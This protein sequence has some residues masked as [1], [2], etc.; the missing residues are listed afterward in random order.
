MI[1]ILLATLVSWSAISS[2]HIDGPITTEHSASDITDFYAFPDADGLVMV[3]NLYPG[4]PTDA[5]FEDR[6]I[7]S[8]LVRS[9]NIQDQST[10]SHPE[11]E[12]KIHCRFN[13]AHLSRGQISC[14]SENGAIS[15]AGP[16]DTITEETGVQIYSGLR[17]DPFIFNGSFAKSIVEKGTLSKPGSGNDMNQLNVL[18]VVIKIPA[19][20]LP[21][22]ALIA[23]ATEVSFQEKGSTNAPEQLD[24]VGRPEITNVTL[25]AKSK[26]EEDL[27]DEYNTWP[28][29]DVPLAAKSDF[30]ARITANIIAYDQLDGIQHWKESEATLA[31]RLL[32]EDYLIVNMIGECASSNNFLSIE[33]AILNGQTPT[34]CGGRF[35]EDDIMDDIFTWYI[36][37]DTKVYK[38][39]ANQI[40]RRP[41]ETFPYLAE[42]DT[43]F[44][45]RAKAWI[46]RTFLL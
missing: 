19:N 37:K 31:G 6:L 12:L 1:S 27:R 39:G 10:V 32:V 43:S 3:M 44:S 29:F 20:Q 2:D 22:G 38:D 26:K 28:T 35:L 34:T 25:D 13:D 15:I 33:K 18:S 41:L 36:S 7:Y 45:A 46:A 8:F 21:E 16:V 40:Y 9:V 4:A 23:A 42:P 17:S 5:H 24:R 11:G 14:Q 30:Q